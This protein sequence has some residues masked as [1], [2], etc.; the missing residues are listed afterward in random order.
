MKYTR[1]P[2]NTFKELQC[3]AGIL[4]DDFSPESGEIGN[5]I[6]ATTGGVTFSATPSFKDYGED[7]DNCPKNMME[8]KRQESWEANMSGTFVTVTATSAKSLVGAADIDDEDET[9]IIPRNDLKT[10]D[11]K[12]V[13]WVGDYSDKNED[14]AGFIAIHLINAL[15]STGF[16]IKTSDKGKGQFAFSYVAHYSVEDQEKVPFELYVKSGT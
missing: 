5:I 8:L 9:H 6:G 14:N 11:F 4:I 10:T 7:I 3:N 1:I 12:D 13:W 16:Q 2:D 15:S